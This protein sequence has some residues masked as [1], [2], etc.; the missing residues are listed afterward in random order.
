MSKETPPARA[1]TQAHVALLT[2]YDIAS[3][4]SEAYYTLFANIRFNWKS[5]QAQPHTLLITTPMAYSR[6]RVL[7]TNLAIAAA[8]SGIP[9]ILVE[10]DLHSNGLERYFG[11][12]KQLGLRQL[13]AESP[14]TT[15]KL[16]AYLLQTFVPGLRLLGGGSQ[17]DGN[18]NA[19]VL[20][21]A[22]LQN[23]MDSLRQHMAEAGGNE[24]I[25]I[26]NGP[27]VLQ[28]PDASLLASCVEQTIMTIVKG[29]TTRAQAKQAQ[30][31][32]QRA[33]ADLAAL[34]MLAS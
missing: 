19:P 28:G 2:D 26:V 15:R 4:M 13:L 14:L 32:L 11:R 10:A 30:E 7:T 23:V 16:A 21:Q 8:Q 31:Q 25:V 33:R 1:S 29:Y 3:P 24:S 22:P 12:Q 17:S 34:V 5:G 20:L 6:Q 27:P 18:T 9:T